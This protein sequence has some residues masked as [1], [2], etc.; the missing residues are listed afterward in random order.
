MIMNTTDEPRPIQ[1]TTFEQC[2]T[3]REKA[4]G[5]LLLKEI[6]LKGQV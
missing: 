2:F 4:M 6:I 5:T 1:Q 3:K